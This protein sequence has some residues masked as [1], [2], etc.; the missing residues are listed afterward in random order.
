MGAAG[1]QERLE[2][3]DIMRS[4]HPPVTH[5]AHAGRP[6]R[7]GSRFWPWPWAGLL[8]AL[9]LSLAGAGKIPSAQ[10]ARAGDFSKKIYLSVTK[11][12]SAERTICVGDKVE[13]QARVLQVVEVV[14]EGL[15]FG[16][17][18][19]VP[20][21]ASVADPG[22]GAISPAANVTS[23]DTDPLGVA[24]FTF[25]A[26]KTGTT[27]VKVDG[28]LI[29]KELLGLVLSSD[30]VTGQLPITVEKC[31][32]RVIVTAVWKMEGPISLF[33]EITDAAL[34]PNGDGKYAGNAD[35]KW[36][37]AWT[38][39][40]PCHVVPHP[41]PSRAYI[42]GEIDAKGDLEVNIIFEDT[43][44]L[45]ATLVCPTGAGEIVTGVLQPESLRLWFRTSGGTDRR[46]P[47]LKGT[48]TLSQLATVT[49][50]PVSGQ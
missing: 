23:L 28:K 39:P 15:Q 18:I 9:A 22:I 13:V 36:T 38:Y 26:K 34:A 19:G 33:A 6:P 40:P 47:A 2:K 43:L 25:A 45:A 49:L 7:A 31:E 1:K 10:A 46:H 8:L 20:L 29:Q 44:G 17:L 5:S 14:G 35:V 32:Y 4:P 42:T 50:I 24:Q 21:Q 48:A 37:S 41:K 11:A 16:R 12:G 30:T 3:R 27:T